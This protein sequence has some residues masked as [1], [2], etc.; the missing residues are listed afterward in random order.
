MNPR[1]D[2]IK[3]YLSLYYERV[4]RVSFSKNYNRM[5]DLWIEFTPQERQIVNKHLT[6]NMVLPFTDNLK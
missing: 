1:S 3:E 4:N 6:T 2:L 5:Q